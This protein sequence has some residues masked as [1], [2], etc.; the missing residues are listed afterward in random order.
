MKTMSNNPREHQVTDPAYTETIVLPTEENATYWQSS[1]EIKVKEARA[2]LTHCEN[3]RGQEAPETTEARWKLGEMLRKSGDT[4]E[5][6][7]ILKGTLRQYQELEGVSGKKAIRVCVSLAMMLHKGRMHKESE[8]YFSEALE[9]MQHVYGEGDANVLCAMYNLG[10]VVLLEDGNAV[11]AMVILERCHGGREVLLGAD[12]ADT[13]RALN[14]VGNCQLRLAKYSDAERSFL[15]AMRG[16]LQALG[17]RH[18]ETLNVM[19]NI[20][21]ALEKRKK[22]KEAIPFAEGALTGR[23]ASLG[24]QHPDTLKSMAQLGNLYSLYGRAAEAKDLY[25]KVCSLQKDKF[26]P[27][28]AQAVAADT[29]LAL[30]LMQ[31]TDG[32]MAEAEQM[33][34]RTHNA[35]VSLH[36]QQSSQA[37]RAMHNVAGWNLRAGDP[38]KAVSQYQSIITNWT[39]IHGAGHPLTIDARNALTTAFIESGDGAEAEVVATTTYQIALKQLGDDHPLTITAKHIL[40]VW[41]SEDAVSVLSV[42]PRGS[43]QTSDM[44]NSATQRGQRTNILNALS[45]DSL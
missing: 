40:N 32:D 14:A 27:K 8:A 11:D 9:G 30:F 20:A 13:L 39:T 34:R 6:I 28:S 41:R 44:D 37:T 26:G 16:M 18:P 4:Q 24:V 36:G 12:H 5:A 42:N 23:R 19:S 7:E 31:G 3:T 35:Q 29:D 33:F 17:K 15:K 10:L 21:W 22:V 38:K 43:G 2:A 45:A 25:A 1:I